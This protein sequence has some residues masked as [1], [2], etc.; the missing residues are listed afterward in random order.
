MQGSTSYYLHFDNLGVRGNFFDHGVHDAER[1]R[2]ALNSFNYY[3]FNCEN[4]GFIR[5]VATSGLTEQYINMKRGQTEVPEFGQKFIKNCNFSKLQIA[6][7]THCVSDFFQAEPSKELESQ[8]EVSPKAN[9]VEEEEEEVAEVEA[10]E[11]VVAEK[12]EEV[13]EVVPEP[14]RV[15]RKY[16]APVSQQ[17]EIPPEP[18]VPI[19]TE[20]P[21]P[22]IQEVTTEHVP[23]QVEA[24]VQPE[25]VEP[26]AEPIAEPISE[27]VVE[28]V[29]EPV[30]EVPEHVPEESSE[31]PE[32][33]V[34]PPVIVISQ[35]VE[36]VAAVEE[37][38]LESIEPEQVPEPADEQVE[39]V[40]EKVEEE[41]V[42]SIPENQPE[43]EVIEN[44]V[45]CCS[46]DFPFSL[47]NTLNYV[48][49]KKNMCN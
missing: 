30:P 10:V 45:N 5:T 42:A 13:E 37:P 35:N 44:P 43:Q 20:V 11:E 49:H 17:A 47:K 7:K 32:P 9:E 16:E 41:A 24:P 46:I 34:E 3:Q 26:V 21:E 39:Q 28:P 38:V 8:I 31:H 18:E 25:V 23:D 1:L 22:E 19:H 27:P 14:V 12:L 33:E 4:C 2:T 40:S 48:T 15:S 36:P 29:S 6:L